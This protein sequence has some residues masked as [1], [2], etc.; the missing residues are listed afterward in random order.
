MHLRTA[1]AHLDAE[2]GWR[3]NGLQVFTGRIRNTGRILA[4]FCILVPS[5]GET[6]GRRVSFIIERRLMWDNP[7][8]QLAP[9]E[10]AGFDPL[11]PV[12][13]ASTGFDLP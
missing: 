12:V 2:P 3:S 9:S 6:D 5:G 4:G 10:G 11:D 13:E 7:D 1:F 8:W